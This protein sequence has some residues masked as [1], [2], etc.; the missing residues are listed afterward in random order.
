MR[1]ISKNNNEILRMQ[2]NHCL[3]IFKILF[4]RAT[5]FGQT[6]GTLK[7]KS[8][9]MEGF[10]LYKANCWLNNA[11]LWSP[12]KCFFLNAFIFF[13]KIFCLATAIIANH[14]FV[15]ASSLRVWW[16]RIDENQR[17][18]ERESIRIARGL[19]ELANI[20]E[21][22]RNTTLRHNGQLKRF[23]PI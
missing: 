6:T 1:E 21:D 15:S 20:K 14:G 3:N 4:H 13:L 9:E 17:L 12:L 23:T 18:A 11:F 7:T 19:R 8:V 16:K 10:T 5:N 22:L 2:K